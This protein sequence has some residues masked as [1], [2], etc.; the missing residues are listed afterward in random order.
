MIICLG[1]DKMTTDFGFTR[2]GVTL[3]KRN[4]KEYESSGPCSFREDFLKLPFEKPI[5]L[6]CDLHMQPIRTI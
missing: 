5:F 1:E 3:K 6:P 4:G 2:S